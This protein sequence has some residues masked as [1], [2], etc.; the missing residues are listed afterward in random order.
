MDIKGEQIICATQQTTWDALNSPDI[1]KKCIPG[2]ESIEQTGPDEFRVG[3]TARVG[4]VSARF[5]GKL[6]L[7]D[8]IAPTSYLIIFEGQ[9]GTAGFGKGTAK[10][11]LSDQGGATKLC[12]E[13]NASVGGKLAQVGSRLVD[14]AAKKVA[15]DFFAAFNQSVHQP[16]P[17]PSADGIAGASAGE[18]GAPQNQ[19]EGVDQ[20]GDV[21]ARWRRALFAGVLMSG[22]ILAIWLLFSPS[23]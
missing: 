10:V 6:T 2:C 9:A 7:A 12:Y 11:Q 16:T 8:V 22:V 18:S 1:L 20:A 21:P 14:S 13:A 17:T 4:P 15:E 23:H 19:S 5:K 3:L